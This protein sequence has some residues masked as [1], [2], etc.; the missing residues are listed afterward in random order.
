MFFKRFCKFAVDIWKGTESTVTFRHIRRFRCDF[1]LFYSH[2][3]ARCYWRR[4]PRQEVSR[5]HGEHGDRRDVSASGGRKSATAIDAVRNPTTDRMF[6]RDSKVG[7]SRIALVPRGSD[8]SADALPSLGPSAA[9][10]SS[11]TERRNPDD[12]GAGQCACCGGWHPRLRW[13][14]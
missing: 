5:E 14:P 12:R 6:R 11:P 10:G 4:V 2:W 13:L 3:A 9:G 1:L 7:R 8:V